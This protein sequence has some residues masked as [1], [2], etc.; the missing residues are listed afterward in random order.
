MATAIISVSIP[1]D[2]NNFLIENPSI[3]P[4]KVLQMK[5]YEM[6]DSAEQAKTQMRGLE[7]RNGRLSAKLNSVL[8]WCEDNK[9]TIPDNVLA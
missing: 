5:L 7:I 6:K 1:A 2:L 3:S 8:E 4:S 9:I